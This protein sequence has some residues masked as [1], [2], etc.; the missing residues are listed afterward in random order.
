MRNRNTTTH[1]NR[2]RS[3]RSTFTLSYLYTCHPTGQCLRNITGRY[4]RQLFAIDRRYR[5][6]QIFTLHRSIPN[7]YHFIQ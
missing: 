7:C 5:T 4:F 1:T 3:T 2:N 6:C